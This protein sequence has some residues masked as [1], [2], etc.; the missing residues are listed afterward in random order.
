MALLFMKT[1]NGMRA[2]HVTSG[3]VLDLNRLD[4]H[5]ITNDKGKL[6]S[7]LENMKNDQM[8]KTL[9]ALEFNVPSRMKKAD[10]VA[11]FLRHWDEIKSNALILQTINEAREFVASIPLA[12]SSSGA[13]AGAETG[14]PS[15]S[16]TAH[17]FEGKGYKL[18]DANT[19][20]SSEC[21]DEWTQIEEVMLRKLLKAN[22]GAVKVDSDILDKMLKK[23]FNVQCKKVPNDLDGTDLNEKN[24]N[25]FTAKIYI[26]TISGSV[27][28]NYHYSGGTVGEELFQVLEEKTGLNHNTICL[29]IPMGNSRLFEYDNLANYLSEENRYTAEVRPILFGGG[30]AVKKEQVKQ[31]KAK[32]SGAKFAEKKASINIA[33][34]S[35]IVSIKE[36]EKELGNFLDGIAT[37]SM[38]TFNSLVSKM[39]LED[40]MFATEILQKNS[41]ADYKL[42]KIAFIMMGKHSNEVAKMN[43]DMTTVTEAIVSAFHYGPYGFAKVM[44]DNTEFTIGTLKKIIDQSYQRKLGKQDALDMEL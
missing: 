13:D 31:E 2:L 40:T 20:V 11:F 18:E 34:L 4:E 43:A 44:A 32:V 37:D 38:G 1:D 41:N 9:E 21:G 25:K 16:A 36:A 14:V 19:S 24:E 15:A 27:V 22:Q 17:V 26:P 29:M 3:M 8:H 30:K 7:L 6:V 33:S 10:Y 39:S 23:K 35:S 42:Q 28:V 12:S 5:D